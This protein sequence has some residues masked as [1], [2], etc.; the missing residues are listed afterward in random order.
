MSGCGRIVILEFRY[1]ITS[2]SIDQL[3]YQRNFILQNYGW[4]ACGMFC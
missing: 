1:E 2:V 3:G 4:S